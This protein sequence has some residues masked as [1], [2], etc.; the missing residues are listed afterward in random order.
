[1]DATPVTLGQEADAWA[2]M[3]AG[4]LARSRADI[5][6]ARRAA[7]RRHGGRHRHQRRRRRSRPP[8]SPSLAAE[9]GLPLRPSANPMVQQGGQGA[10]AEASAGL[11]GIAVALTKIANDIRLLASGP[12]AGLG[13][14]AAARAA[15]RVV[16]HA[17]QGQPGAVRVGQPGRGPGVRQRRHGRVRRVAGHP[18]AEHVPAGDGRRP[19][20]SR[21]RCW[22]TCAGCSPSGASPASRPTRSA[23]GSTPS[24]RRRIATALNPIIGYARAA[25]LVHRSLDERRSIIDL[26]IE[27]GILEEEEARRVLDP[28]HLTHPSLTPSECLACGGH[29]AADTPMR[30]NTRMGRTGGRPRG[31]RGGC[32]RR[33]GTSPG[34]PTRD[35]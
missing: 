16:D 33:S 26:V 3:L 21:A 20:S 7:A 5:D 15:G 1:M 35:P 8:S 32:W 27:D 28:I 9:T 30:R 12:S 11:R 34:S 19:A 6:V 22:P 14:A 23:A 17:G 4:A 2:G 13:R 10:L 29:A 24:A 31:R 18:R 25:E